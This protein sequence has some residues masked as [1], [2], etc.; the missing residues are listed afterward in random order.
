MENFEII[1][2]DSEFKAKISASVDAFN[3]D[4]E[5]LLAFYPPESHQ[6]KK[7]MKE[8]L[9]TIHK[10]KA[11]DST[12]KHK[13]KSPVIGLEYWYEKGEFTYVLYTPSREIEKLLRKQVYTHYSGSDVKLKSPYI[14]DIEK[15]EYITG[16]RLKLK[17]HY[18]EPV[19]S[20]NGPGRFEINPFH[21]IFGELDT[22]DNLRVIMQ[23]LFKPAESDWTHL[24][25]KNV[26]EYAQKKREESRVESM[27]FGLKKKTI[28]PTKEQKKAA[29][30]IENQIG[31][32]GYY[33][34]FRFFLVS[35]NKTQLESISSELAHLFN[36]K[37]K[38][39]L[40]QTFLPT[41]HKNK[42]DIQN[43]VVDTIL[44]RPSK[45][46]QPK[47]PLE[48][49]KSTKI[50]GSETII[51]NIPEL[52]TIAQIPSKSEVPLDSISWTDTPI[53]GRMSAEAGF[54]E[55]SEEET[56]SIEE[57]RKQSS[58]LYEES[59][60]DPEPPEPP[61]PEPV[62][63]PEN[64][65]STDEVNDMLDQT[66]EEQ[67]QKATDE[68]DSLLGSNAP[69]E[70]DEQNEEPVVDED[71]GDIHEENDTPNPQEAESMADEDIHEENDTQ[72]PQEE[73]TVDEDTEDIDEE[74]ETEQEDD[75]FESNIDDIIDF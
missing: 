62:S 52:A 11:K 53:G 9:R 29:S 25:T 6:G 7:G 1:E 70:P 37:F 50:S 63:E 61:E 38:S 58:E 67:T 55:I 39:E 30:M 47:S 51:M 20:I 36:I 27:Y 57:R 35:N 59:Q 73:S 3:E 2:V 21:S 23:I 12:F 14:F 10:Y 74:D 26:E 32:L 71:A 4:S 33:V 5:R 66:S 18:F 45:M 17:H 13:N 75:K 19:K 65:N 60:D 43:E 69:S 22:Q 42:E 46:Y 34:N 16:G 68:V 49:I 31:K 8:L 15:G 28:D 48:Y 24:H 56:K 44:R 40:G 64:D 72:K 41:N 54:D